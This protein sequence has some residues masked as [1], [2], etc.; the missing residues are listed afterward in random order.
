[1]ARV[2]RQ[3]PANRRSAALPAVRFEGTPTALDALVSVPGGQ[4]REITVDVA[5]P[6]MDSAQPVRALTAPVGESHTRVRL[7]LA[8][9][10]PPGAYD[11]TVHTSH[12][13]IPAVVLVKERSHLTLTPSI[14]RIAAQ[15]GG[16]VDQHLMVFNAGNVPC[17]IGRTYGFGLFDSEGLD[18][19]VGAGL[20]ADVSG[21]ERVA[22]M[23]DSLAD[24]HGGLV[25]VTVREGAGILNPGAARQLVTALRF[26]DQLK[27]GRQYFATWRLHDLHMAVFVDVF[28]PSVTSKEPT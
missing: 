22:T 8:A 4:R 19:A 20:L 25:R 26:S 18:R 14:L 13:D 7:V 9:G 5:L 24:S 23:A 15:P 17:R 21:L 10:T 3:A 1:M 16:E 28:K 2:P 11:A 6:D 12:D 27:P